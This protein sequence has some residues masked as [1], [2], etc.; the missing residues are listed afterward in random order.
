[1]MKLDM[2]KKSTKKLTNRYEILNSFCKNSRKLDLIL[3]IDRIYMESKMQKR[4]KK[5]VH[6][7]IFGDFEFNEL[8]NKSI[9]CLKFTEY[10]GSLLMIYGIDN[11]C[12]LKL[13]TFWTGF[14]KAD[15]NKAQFM[16][17]FR[18]RRF[19]GRFETHFK[20]S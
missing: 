11:G 10:I 9:S 16:A 17:W 6:C 18:F 4:T 12:Y 2:K 8:I 7:L 14:F 15:S 13:V 20:E 3:C 19:V 1:M 5:P